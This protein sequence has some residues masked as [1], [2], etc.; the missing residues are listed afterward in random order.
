MKIGGS[1]ILHIFCHILH[2]C[3]TK[4]GGG[5]GICRWGGSKFLHIEFSFAYIT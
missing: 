2:I 3:H 5:G 1:H 4:T